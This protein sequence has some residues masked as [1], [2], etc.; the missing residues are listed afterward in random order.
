MGGA[1]RAETAVRGHAAQPF[2]AHVQGDVTTR[3]LGFRA[4]GLTAAAADHEV[5]IV[6]RGA[7]CRCHR[8]GSGV[9]AV[10]VEGRRRA[11]HLVRRPC[12]ASNGKRAIPIQ[13]ALALHSGSCGAEQRRSEPQH[14][15]CFRTS[16]PASPAPR[17]SAGSALADR[18]VGRGGRS[19]PGAGETRDSAPAARRT[20]PTSEDCARGPSVRE[21]AAMVLGARHPDAQGRAASLGRRGGPHPPAASRPHCH[22]A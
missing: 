20:A 19:W 6:V 2:T 12:T 11:L 16:S 21:L 22:P 14:A 1:G 5:V 17:R 7:G 18:T 3:H 4:T 10:A 15:H 8:S 9:L 13:H